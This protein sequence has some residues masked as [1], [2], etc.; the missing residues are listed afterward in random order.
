LVAEGD[1]AEPQEAAAGFAHVLDIFLEPPRR[2]DRAQFGVEGFSESLYKE[3]GPLG[4]MTIVEPGGFRTDFAGISTDLREGRPEYDATVGATVR[5]QRDYDGKQPGD[6]AK[7]AAALLHIAS[8]SDPPLRL[9]LGSDSC[10]AAEQAALQKL[11][12]DR[13]WKDLSIS[14]DYAP[15]DF[16][17]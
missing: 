17:A 8:P 7:A 16:S 13:K 1:G 12:L 4:I 5:F 11:E 14:T 2:A 10:N 3:V 6:P 15:D 9:L